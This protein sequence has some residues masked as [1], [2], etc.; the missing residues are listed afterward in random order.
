MSRS[1]LIERKHQVIAQLQRARRQ[2]EHVQGL[3]D[4]RS[5][6]RAQELEALLA[7]LMAEEHRLRLQ[8]DRSKD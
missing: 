7:E 4:P 2:L 3:S 5:Q 8:I 6:R 1:H